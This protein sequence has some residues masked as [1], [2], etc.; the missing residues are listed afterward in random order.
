M[1]GPAKRRHLNFENFCRVDVPFPPIEE[2]RQIAQA[3]DRGT[4][5]IASSIE[6]L[7][8]QI[9]SLREY[10]VRLIADVATG[11]LDV[12]EAVAGLPGLDLL[13]ADEGPDDDFNRYACSE[14]SGDTEEGGPGPDGVDAERAEAAAGELTAE[15]G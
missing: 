15:G 1:P 9:S 8:W 13:A 6:R 3:V 11:K 10:R 2:Q 7:R 14:A 4:G 12:R 5:H